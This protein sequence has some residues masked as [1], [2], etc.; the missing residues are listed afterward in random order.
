[1]KNPGARGS[2]A[3]R[4][5][6]RLRILRGP[7]IA[8]GPGKADLLEAIGRAAKLKSAAESLGMSYMRAWKLVSAMNR[9]F[10][11]P[12]VTLSRGGSARG[13][14]ILTRSGRRVLSLYREMESASLR[15]SGPAWKTLRSLL[16]S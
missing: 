4:L 14:A 7:E 9:S 6:P 11:E 12:L 3:G 13:G 5:R 8:L 10:R 1:M 15:A 16:K 2:C